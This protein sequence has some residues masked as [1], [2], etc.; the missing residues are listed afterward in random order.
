VTDILE[1]DDL[2]NAW[3]SLDRK[4]DLQNAL[5]LDQAREKRFKTLGRRLLPLRFGK[6]LQMLFG[7]LL[8]LP[9]V[10]VWT[11]LRDGSLLF[12]SGIAMHVYGVVLICLGAIMHVKLS[13]LDRGESVLENQKRLARARRFQVLSGMAVGLPWWFIWVPCSAVVAAALADVDMYANAPGPMA[14]MFGV[15]VAGWA[16]TIVAYRWAMNRPRWAER[17][18]RSAAGRS[19][20]RA[21]QTLDELNAFEKG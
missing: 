11:E 12:W 2:K 6:V 19:F 21:R 17:V 8:I 20:E 13:E 9:A 14:W 15:G 18:E 7:G 4:L 10:S 5:L 1:L 3:Q 16:L